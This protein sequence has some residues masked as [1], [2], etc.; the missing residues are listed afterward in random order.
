MQ[1]KG[2]K[3][4]EKKIN[5]VEGNFSEKKSKS[6]REIERL[7]RE[8]EDFRAGIITREEIINYVVEP[9]QKVTNMMLLNINAM[10]NILIAKG[11]FT[12]EELTEE[13]YKVNESIKESHEAKENS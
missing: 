10:T 5:V 4:M 3:I 13:V 11:I 12:E 2:G 7:T 9:F 6:A 1:I 8:N